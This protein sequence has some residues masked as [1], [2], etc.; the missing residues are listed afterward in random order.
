MK[1]VFLPGLF[2][3]VLTACAGGL[4]SGITGNTEGQSTEDFDVA[5]VQSNTPMVM[6]GDTSADVRFDIT[7]RNRTSQPYTIRRIALQS[8]GGS[9]YRLP[10]S[11]RSYE[12]QIAP[13]TEAKLEYWA[14]TEV[15]DSTIGARAPLV[16]R[17]TLSVVGAD[18]TPRE[19]IFTGRVNGHVAVGVTKESRGGG[20][21]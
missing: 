4:G 8:L 12:M 13:G 7:V 5:V 20:W 10:I 6:E 14:S 17:T 16:L 2:L 11:T 19:E 21:M 9:T 3:F 1:R 15:S 18:G